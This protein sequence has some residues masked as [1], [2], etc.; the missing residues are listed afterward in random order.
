METPSSIIPP[1]EDVRLAAVHRYE[2][3][4]TPCEG[5][6]DRVTL[7]AARLFKAPIS[8]VSIVDNDRV[9]FKS[10]HGIDVEQVGRLPGLC[11]SAILQ[12]EPLIVPDAS[13]DPNALANPIVAGELGLR[14][15]AGAPLTTWDGHNLGAICV[16]DKEPREF[17]EEDVATLEQLAEIVVHELELR[18]VTRNVVKSERET[19]ALEAA[20]RGLEATEHERTR[21]AR[22]LHDETLQ[23]LGALHM[24]LVSGLASPE[25]LD[26][27]VNE[28]ADLVQDEVVKLRHLIAELRPAVL[29]Q[30][31][32]EAALES[33]GRKV[34]VIDGLEVQLNLEMSQLGRRLSASD[35][36]TLYRA[37][38]EALANAAKHS[39]ARRVEVTVRAR[40]RAIEAI[41]TDD[42]VGFEVE[43]I[44]SGFG[45]IG[46]RERATLVGGE[47]ELRTA[48]GAGTR[49]RFVM[50]LGEPFSIEDSQDSS[51][52]P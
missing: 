23:N 9:W 25:K 5:A 29:D 36:S 46:M 20:R 35:E 26:A 34:R 8:I 49:V 42:G 4:D 6:F 40:E 11:A 44:S 48:P 39:A 43:S 13:I 38:Q 17:G 47:L 1:D 50:P 27:T 12:R 21:W 45:L 18:I 15:Y 41:V 16:L 14:F 31:G 30:V 7:L 32:L 52:N 51:S 10:R 22:E 28:A 2:I 19:R 33:L 24:L 3:L 37:V